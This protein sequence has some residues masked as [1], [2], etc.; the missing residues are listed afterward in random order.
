MD[1]DRGW[2][3]RRRFLRAGGIAAVGG[4]AGCSRLPFLGDSHHEVGERVSLV[5]GSVAV[6]AVTLR[7]EVVTGFASDYRVRRNPSGQWLV[8]AVDDT[9][10]ID[11]AAERSR[12][13]IEYEGGRFGPILEE[14]TLRLLHAGPTRSGPGWD[15]ALP[16]PA[17]ELE[18]AA[19]VWTDGDQTVRWTLPSKVL[20]HATSLP[21]FVVRDFAAPTAVE[22][23][24]SPRVSL[25]VENR[26]DRS[27][28]ANVILMARS[29]T[30]ELVS[31]RGVIGFSVELAWDE[32][33]TSEP[34]LPVDY[35]R[36]EDRFEVELRT[37][38]GTMSQRVRVDSGSSGTSS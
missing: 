19:V 18:R 35:E 26:G 15:L 24:E 6:K 34:T 25:T 28:V 32:S 22:R 27:G 12:F 11:E 5:K 10:V 1:A 31:F 16:F 21:E 17:I 38:A 9:T 29:R 20:E 36:I 33:R 3:S 2:G 14:P 13:G 30:G 4:L 37:G 8:V 7:Y 23:G